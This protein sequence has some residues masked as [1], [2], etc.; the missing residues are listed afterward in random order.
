MRKL[1][2]WDMVTLNG[3]FEG[4]DHDISWFVFEDELEN[5]IRET[6]AAADTLLFGR[7]TYEMMASYWSSAEGWIADFMNGVEKIVFSRTLSN[8][9]WTNTR[10]V[11]DHV[12][13]EIAK[14]KD[15]PG[16]E[17]FVFG[18]ADLS[19]TLIKEG[20]VDEYRIAI[21]PVVLGKGVPLFKEGMKRLDLRLLETK[22]L[23]SGVVILHYAPASK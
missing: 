10:L 6:Q 12:P 9:D 11:K 1:I 7:V 8:A 15:A 14:L 5:Y 22:P 23:K 17:I 16:R 3:M 18:S 2:L 21:N 19:A 4:P 20:L 13:E